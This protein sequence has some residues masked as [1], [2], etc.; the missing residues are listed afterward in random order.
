VPLTDVDND[1]LRR[2]LNHQRGAWND[3]VDRYLGLIYHVIH[4]SAYL[5]SVALRPEDV[6]DLAADVLMAVVANDYAV[7]RHFRGQASLAT[8][9]TVVARR[10]VVGALTK[11]VSH[12]EM[13][14]GNGRA[15]EPEDKPR[16]ERGLESIEEV[17]SLLK[18]LPSR[19]RKVV[20]LFYLEGRTYE[21]IAT[22]LHVPI[23][24]IGP[25]LS[26]AKKVLRASS[27]AKRT[28]K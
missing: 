17:Q 7:L 10:V 5:R 22:A 15:V 3:F 23:N 12:P 14:L 27:R 13:Q 21:D 18:R 26:R 2:C 24:S 11:R 20:R 25:I 19:E 9:L 4:H 6:E 28:E 8:Y 16:V 1:L